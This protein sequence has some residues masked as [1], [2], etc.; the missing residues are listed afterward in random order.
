MLCN[1]LVFYG[2]ELLAQRPRWTTTPCQ[3]SVTAYSIYSQLPPISGG[4]L[5]HSQPDDTPYRG[6]KGPTEHGALNNSNGF[7]V[8]AV[9]LPCWSL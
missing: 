1:K 3:P 6:D 9:G 4:H 8:E 5:L 7:Y 2:E